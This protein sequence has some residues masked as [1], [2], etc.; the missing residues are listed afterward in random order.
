MD[1]WYKG[2]WKRLLHSDRAK[3]ESDVKWPERVASLF[4]R[5]RSLGCCEWII[6]WTVSSL[7]LDMHTNL[8]ETKEKKIKKKKDS[9]EDFVTL[10][11]W[12]IILWNMF[13]EEF[14]SYETI[15]RFENIAKQSTKSFCKKTCNYGEI[16]LSLFYYPKNEKRIFKLHSIISCA[17]YFFFFFQKN[18][19]KCVCMYNSFLNIA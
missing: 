15:E 3:W 17:H 5:V 14:G 7:N 1:V 6:T 4:F 18:T 2:W 11:E 16:H 13:S 10:C 8:R 19:G 12:R 9:R